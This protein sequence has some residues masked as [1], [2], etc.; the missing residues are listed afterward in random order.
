MQEFLNYEIYGNSGLDY[1]IALGV[2]FVSLIILKLAQKIIIARLKILAKKTK[3]KVDDVMVEIL[4]SIKPP[5]YLIVAIYIGVRM[6]EISQS[7]WGVLHIAFLSVIV[8]EGIQA[9]QKIVQFITYR[10]L[11]KNSDDKQAKMT[12]KTLN[13]FVQIALWSFGLILILSNAGVNVSSLLAGLGIGGIAIALALQNILGDVFSS[14]SILIDKPFQVGDFIKIGTDLGTVEKIGIKTTRLRTLDGQILVVSNRELTT[15]RVENFQQI[16]KRRSLFN[17]GLVYETSREGLEKAKVLVKEIIEKQA[18]A[19]Y[20]RCHFKS[21]G[22]FSLNL[23]VSFYVSADSYQEF[24]DVV[25]KVNLNI[26]SAFKENNLSFAY[27][28][29]LQYQKRI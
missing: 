11:K 12:S 29:H 4:A 17:L 5:F 13:I 3:T 16:K 1:L 2:F 7:V 8:Y 6:L 26:F 10:A 23:E 27:P 20:D 15:T 9:G 22:D 21:Y 19:E 18:C 28:T 24:L 14:F 25:E